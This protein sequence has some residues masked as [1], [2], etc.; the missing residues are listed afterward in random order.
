MAR[1]LGEVARLIGE[2]GESCVLCIDFDGTLAEIVDDPASAVALPGIPGLLERAA[3]SLGRVAVVSGRPLAF[4]ETALGKVP[5]VLL[6]GLYGAEARRRDGALANGSSPV[7]HSARARL[8][9]AM[10][11]L[12]AMAPGIELERKDLSVVVHWRQAPERAAELDALG[13]GVAKRHGLEVLAAKMA[14]ELAVP[15]V[16]DKGHVVRRLATGMRTACF[17]GDD[18]GDLAA[19]AAL[20]ELAGAG[21]QAIRVAVQSP[22]SPA[23]LV[24]AADLVVEGPAGTRALLQAI[25]AELA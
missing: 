10:A 8:D 5:D 24:A 14:L 12:D 15:G 6:F 22:E 16:G 19:F 18:R 11:E 17:V 20:G 21:L 7:P 3:S 25:V 23:E 13:R 2:A 9:G 4:L 1:S